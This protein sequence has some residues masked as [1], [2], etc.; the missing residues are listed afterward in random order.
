MHNCNYQ[1]NLIKLKILKKKYVSKQRYCV[2]IKENDT[3]NKFLGF[4]V[5]RYL[6]LLVH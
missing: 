4:I 6:S 3:D 1:K 2:N 5:S